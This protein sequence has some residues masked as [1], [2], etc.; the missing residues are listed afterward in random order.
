MLRT[1][2]K[3]PV[4]S[5]LVYVYLINDKAYLRDF[6]TTYTHQGETYGIK[7]ITI[8][9]FEKNKK[10]RSGFSTEKQVW[11]LPREEAKELLK[12]INYFLE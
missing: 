8:T 1:L 6:Q 11:Q 2:L 4:E 7:A 9:E 3:C 12:D 5:I 10:V